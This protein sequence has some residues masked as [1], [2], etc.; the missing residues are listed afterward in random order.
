MIYIHHNYTFYRLS[1][2][3]FVNLFCTLIYIYKHRKQVMCF[4]FS[5]C[6][7]VIRICKIQGSNSNYSNSYEVQIK[8]KVD[9]C[10]MKVV[11]CK[12][13]LKILFWKSET[14]HQW[15]QLCGL[16]VLMQISGISWH[17]TTKG[18][19]RTVICRCMT[20]GGVF[21]LINGRPQL[22]LP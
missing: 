4:T 10:K 18:I 1:F 6:F 7:G 22:F 11:K 3:Y 12:R 17:A 20:K 9:Y 15:C 16:V 21:L 14:V 2:R 19:Q 8:V 5:E 13:D